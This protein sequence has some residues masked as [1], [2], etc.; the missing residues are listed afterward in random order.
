MCTNAAHY[1]QRRALGREEGDKACDQFVK[2]VQVLFILGE[3]FLEL[4]EQL[5]LIF[6][7]W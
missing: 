6:T 7:F 5:E 1:C 4:K 2:S 3:E